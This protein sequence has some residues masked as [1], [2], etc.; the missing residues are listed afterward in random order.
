MRVADCKNTPEIRHSRSGKHAWPVVGQGSDRT[1]GE[2]KG[3]ASRGSGSR[4]VLE[5]RAGD[6]MRREPSFGTFPVPWSLNKSEAD[7]AAI[8]MLPYSPAH[9][10][11]Q[12]LRW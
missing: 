1:R 2:Q 3:T 10:K 6:F 5:S 11:P 9:R 8:S 12:N 4:Y 7:R